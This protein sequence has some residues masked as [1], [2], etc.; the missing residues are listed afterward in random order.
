MLDG[1][2]GICV[3]VIESGGDLELRFD[4]GKLEIG[5]CQDLY[6]NID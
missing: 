3:V 1:G 2:D 5:G 6:P 4:A